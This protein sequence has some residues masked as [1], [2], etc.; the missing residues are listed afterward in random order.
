MHSA[1]ADDLVSLQ[2]TDVGVLTEVFCNW[3]LEFTQLAAGPFIASACGIQ[4]GPVR[5]ISV[6][7]NRS[8]LC[9]VG[10]L[11]QYDSIM[12]SK[13]R[14]HSDL[15][16]GRELAND[17]CLVLRAGAS[18]EIVSRD[19]LDVVM[20][21][22]SNDVWQTT[23]HLTD[24]LMPVKKGVHLSTPG[25]HWTESMLQCITWIFDS[26][27]KYPEGAASDAVRNSMADVL[28]GR[29]RDP[30]VSPVIQPPD[31]SRGRVY[32]HIAVERARHFIYENL[33][34][35]FRLSDVCAYA[36]VQPRSLEYG[37]HEALGMT[38][39]AYIKTLRLNRVH[40][41]LLASES[42]ERTV[43]EIALDCGFQH[44][45]QFAVDYRKFFGE[46]PSAAHRRAGSLPNR[47]FLF[48]TEL[49]VG[50]ESV[51]H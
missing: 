19:R 5:V 48:K 33:D 4:V 50:S 38:P 22:A 3:Q 15:Q 6:L 41:E 25:A 14:P 7:F 24:N 16:L 46:S 40:R 32:R 47:D 49:Y 17:Q 36:R 10:S 13:Q 12:L 31:R 39:I 44:L 29:M 34:N 51:A 9:R 28:L 26:F 2:C 43:T 18:A 42:A 1:V 27:C 21:A 23:R 20:I 30:V 8:L 35:P 11:E 37:F 45:S